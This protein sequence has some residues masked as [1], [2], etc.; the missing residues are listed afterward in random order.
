MPSDAVICVACGLD[1]RTGRKIRTGI[2]LKKQVGQDL[3]RSRNRTD[4]AVEHLEHHQKFSD[5]SRNTIDLLIASF[6]NQRSND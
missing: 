4:L 1:T 2:K 5:R 6:A 3:V